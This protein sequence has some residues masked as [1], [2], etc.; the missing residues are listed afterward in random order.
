MFFFL[1]ETIMSYL[2]LFCQ[3]NLVTQSNSVYLI[4]NKIKW[5]IGIKNKRELQELDFNNKIYS[6]QII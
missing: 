4:K 2:N 6:Q 3:F 1:I 5:F